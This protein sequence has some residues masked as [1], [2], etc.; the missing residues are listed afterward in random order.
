VGDLGYLWFGTDYAAA[1]AN[2]NH[3]RAR[4][5]G[6]YYGDTDRH[7]L[8]IRPIRRRL[9]IDVSKYLL[10]AA[11][12]AI[13]AIAGSTGSTGAARASTAAHSRPQPAPVGVPGRW[14][15]I[16]NWTGK[17]MTKWRH[18]LFG[19]QCTTAGRITLTRRG[20]LAL[21]TSGV[22]DNCAEVASRRI[23]KPGEV[24]QT[25]LKWPL[26]KTGH[27]LNWPAFWLTTPTWQIWP[28]DGEIDVA[29][30]W[31]GV[32]V[33]TSYHYSATGVPGFA[34]EA[35][36]QSYCKPLP[37]KPGW[38]AYSVEWLPGKLKY[39]YDGKLLGTV[40]G[41]FIASKPLSVVYDNTTGWPGGQGPSTVLVASTRVWRRA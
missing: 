17:D 35:S 9:A 7:N 36:S 15:L 5:L 18:T 8:V 13:L 3:V 4:R 10:T 41:S 12:A 21:T 24:I 25:Q 40:T 38:H 16:D 14:K 30:D 1:L 22:V 20:D 19:D 11:S 33:C 31:P 37:V 29:E 32:G 26:T 39:Y 27:I 6:G 23:I 2:S 34:G 28:V